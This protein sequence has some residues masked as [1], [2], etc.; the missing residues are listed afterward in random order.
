M[1][2]RKRRR[3][4]RIFHPRSNTP[5]SQ[6]ISSTSSSPVE[7]RHPLTYI[8]VSS[9][10]TIGDDESLKARPR[11]LTK[12]HRT[13]VFGSLRSLQS[14]DEEE[15]VLTKSESKA[16]SVNDGESPGRGLFGNYVKRAAELQVAGNSMFRKRTQYVVLTESHLIRFK[17]QAKAS[18]MFPI[19]PSGSKSSLPRN[20]SS[21][22]SYSDMQMSAYMDITQGV[23]LE[24]VIAIYKIED[25]RP[26]FTFEVSYLDERGKKSS[27]VQFSFTGLR[28]AEAWMAAI[29]ET[30]TARRAQQSQLYQQRTLEYLARALER[31]RDYDP[32]HFRA[33]KV[34]QRAPVRPASRAPSDE[35]AKHSSSTCYLAIGINKVHL[36]PLPRTSGRSSSTSLSEL[37]SPTTFGIT[38]LTSIRVF[39]SDDTFEIYFRTPLRQPYVA[40][41]ASYDAPQIALWLRYSS[42]YLRPEWTVQPFVFD[43]P[44]GL[45]DQMH[46]PTFPA[47]DN[48]CFDRTLVAFCSAYEVDTSRIYYSVD[49]DCEDAPCFRLLPPQT[50]PSYS[51]LE[52]LAVFR[53]LRYNEAFTSISFANINLSPLRSVHDPF[54]ADSDGLCTRSG[55]IVDL[56]GHANLSVLQQEIRALA[57]RSRRLRR[58]DFSNARVVEPVA[59]RER[60]SCGIPEALTPLCK[61]SL[62][63]V[64]WVTLTGI[65]LSDNDLEFLVDAASERQCHLRALEIGE[66]GLSVHDVDVLLATLCVHDNTMEVIDI[67]GTQGRFSPELFQRAMGAFSRIRRLNLTRVQ[68]TAGPEPLIAPETLLSWRL[69][70]LHLNGTN[71]NEQS[72]DTISAYLASPKSDLLRELSVNQCGLTGKDL[73]VFF[74]SMTRETGVARNMHVSASENRLGVGSSLLSKCIARNFAPVSVTMRMMDFEKEFHFRELVAA[75]T[76]NT[77]IRSLDI[78]QASL[79]YDASMETCEALKELFATNMTLEELDISG[80][81]AHLDVARFG[82]GLNIALTGLEKNKALKMLRVE[83]QNLGLQG[84][85]TLAGVIESNT[86]L[87]EIHCEHNDIN[88]QSFTVLVNALKKNT[89]LLYL[90]S[91]EADRAKSIEK[92][93]EEFEAL[94]QSEEPKSPKAG[95]LR[96]SMHAIAQRAPRHRRH[97]SSVSA[98]SNTSFTEQDINATISALEEQWNTQLARLQQYLSRNYQLASGLTW[99]EL[100]R[101]E[102]GTRP[103]T[104]NSLGRMLAQVSFDRPGSIER[105]TSPVQ[106]FDEKHATTEKRAM[107]FTLPED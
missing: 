86:C 63:N 81:F 56:P 40:S 49:Y 17:N 16:S 83:H 80:D 43:V 44:E 87:A 37:D 45:E 8:E 39:S 97:S 5:D 99:E 62:T 28:D 1:A 65:P 92:V 14:L 73:A 10:P 19:I 54:G 52:L 30:A 13:S 98:H 58:F 42:E 79:P 70:S 6:A 60:S 71:L 84:A 76:Q 32:L 82:I 104:A 50:G 18:E 102:T 7:Q 51:I 101:N 12:P 96:K 38:S 34:T 77:T 75:L 35:L 95:A 46:P 11:V 33:F 21:I 36:I 72:V 41:L 9:S 20:M 88:L 106:M 15:R 91:Q 85:N 3:S 29:R 57:T 48:N 67:S 69:E 55:V 89:T 22:G 78:S 53:A 94:E 64:D 107:V 61:K 74:R 2:D 93:K 100:D 24:E 31:E 68:K 23:P 25:G 27:A 26:Y 90:P 105:T 59:N 66:C 47:E 103:T 4:L